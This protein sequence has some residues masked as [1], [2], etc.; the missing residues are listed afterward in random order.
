MAKVLIVG[1]TGLVGRHVLALLLADARFTAVVAPVRRPIA[2]AP[3]LLAPVVDFDALATDAPWWAADTVISTLGTTIR[4]AGSRE[5]FAKIDHDLP[6][7]VAGMAR[8]RG[9]TS[10]IVVSALGADASSR[11]FYNRTKGALEA[12]LE[13]LNFPSLTLVRPGLI[14]GKRD[15][16]RPLERAASIAL[17]A[18]GPILPRSFRINPAIDIARAIVAAALKNQPGVHIVPS[19]DLAWERKPVLPPH[20]GRHVPCG[21]RRC[22]GHFDRIAR[23]RR[24][25]NGIGLPYR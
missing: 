7:Q 3:R 5:A 4:K 13:A 25:A 6:L 23:S 12:D 20:V 2:A 8:S 19:R 21:Y 17:R 15:E 14:G 22:G 11:Y 16:R 9:A 1:A 10:C 24:F 18:L